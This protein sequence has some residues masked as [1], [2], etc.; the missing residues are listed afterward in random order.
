[1]PFLWLGFYDSTAMVLP[2]GVQVYGEPLLFK[3]ASWLWFGP[4]PAGFDEM[5]S[6]MGFAAW[7]GMLATALNLLPF[8]QLDGGHLAYVI[9]GRRAPIVYALTLAGTVLLVIRSMSLIMVAV[10]MLIMAFFLG[11]RHPHV[12]DESIP[13]DPKRKIIAAIALV[14]FVLCFT[15]V[16]VEI[17]IEPAPAQ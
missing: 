13:L 9:F 10:M 8:G 14:I 17:F 12:P 6:P 15:P 11:L 16:P 5:L 2:P 4:L 1:M 7:F 3:L